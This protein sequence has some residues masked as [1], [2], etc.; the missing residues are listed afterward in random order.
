MKFHGVRPDG[1]VE[2]ENWSG[3]AVTG[4]SFTQAAGSW[5]VP[6][7]DCNATPNSYAAYW[8]GIDGYSS[9][10]VEQTGTESDCNG[11]TPS[12]YAWY[13]FFPKF[14]ATITSLP[15]SPG[16]KISAQVNYNGKDFILT[17]TNITT[18]NSY[19][20]TER[21]G[22]ARRASAEWITEALCCSKGGG[23]LPLPDFGTVSFG[24]DYT[25]SSGSNDATDTLTSGP[26]GQF[27]SNVQAITM[28]SS[29]GALEAVP[30]SLSSDGTSF[31]M[32]WKSE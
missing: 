3:Y 13:E 4:S 17:I 10:T 16:D 11:S 25:N 6:A 14:P 31:K 29:K 32:A 20:E 15:I 2:S 21:V 8:V 24:Q 7:V 27:G 23:V 26:I 12:Y 19:T 18:G 28:V 5:I 9:T 30:S 22:E 1:T